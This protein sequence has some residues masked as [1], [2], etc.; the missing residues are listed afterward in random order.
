[1]QQAIR[2]SVENDRCEVLRKWR[3]LS[4]HQQVTHSVQCI[5]SNTQLGSSKKVERTTQQLL[6]ATHR[7]AFKM[8]YLGLPLIPADLKSIAPYLQRAHET[9]SQDPVISYWC[10]S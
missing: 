8:S 6:T 1:M 7:V 2:R 9:K 10:T 4:C 3:G 5:Q